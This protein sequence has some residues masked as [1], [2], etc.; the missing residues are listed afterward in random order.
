ML[1]RLGRENLRELIADLER[2]GIDCDL[3]LAGEM[4][5]TLAPYQ[6]AWIEEERELATRFGLEVEV[7]Q[8][9][10]SMQAEVASPTYRGGSGSRTAAVSSI[11]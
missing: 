9:A 2:Y 1:E 3:E 11:R 6:D 5:P 7:F 8:D 4:S 10:E